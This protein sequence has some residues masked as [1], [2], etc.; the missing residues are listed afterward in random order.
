MERVPVGGAPAATATDDQQCAAGKPGALA[1]GGAN[2]RGQFECG[3]RLCRSMAQH[4]KKWGLTM[5]NKKKPDVLVVGAGPVGLLAALSLAKN[6]VQVTIV[7]QEWRTGAHSYALALHP[8][9][10]RLLEEL[11]LLGEVL[12]KAY[13]VR[14]IGLYDAATRRA[15]MRIAGHEQSA[16]PLAVMPQD[17]LERTLEEAL[18]R[19]GVKVL[20]NHAVS[21]LAV[22]EDGVVAT[23]EKLAKESVGYG[24]AHTEWMIAKSYDMKVPLVIGADGH[25]SIARRSL[26]IEFP[27]VAP[28][29]HYAVFECQL[30]AELGQEMRIVMGD[31]T[32]DVLWPLPD[33]C[34]RWSFQL[35]DASAPANTRTK[36]RL[37]VEIGG[38]R[39]PALD[40]ASLR[41]FLA[42]RAP[43]FEAR[44]ES[45]RWRLVVRFERRLASAFGSGR[46]WIAG[47]A[48]HLT[49]PAGMQSMNVGLRE[50]RE[51]ADMMTS[52]LGDRGPLDQLQE[53]GRRRE[54]E[55]R[56]LLG[57]E[58]NLM[59]DELADPW[60]CQCSDRLLPCIPASCTELA[61]LVQ[62]LRLK[63]PSLMMGSP[64]RSE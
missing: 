26:G 62:Q 53:Y 34:C 3:W 9:S 7:D 58:G 50:A 44:I 41:A 48:G 32:T 64:H 33:R 51:L 21:R 24:V 54:A 49:G 25:R 18:R 22:E 45:F 61:G 10:L 38:A 31:R 19:A 46:V 52:V 16:M 11:G 35:L 55:W 28:A 20:W 30:N 14:M 29:L 13:H 37:P 63:A 59:P 8:R 42:E 1:T 4:G 57:L 40:E 12:A 5:F 2:Y 6:G 23:I 36:S 43:W 47:D 15:E 56:C 39:F 60:V 17:V 27:E